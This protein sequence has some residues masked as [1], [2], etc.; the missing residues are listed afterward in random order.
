MIDLKHFL[1]TLKIPLNIRN[2]DSYFFLAQCTGTYL[3]NVSFIKTKSDLSNYRHNNST[4]VIL[5]FIISLIQYVNV[6]LL[7]FTLPACTLE[8]FMGNIE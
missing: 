5:V 8:C 4:A 7:F 6:L 1:L 3:S 2:R